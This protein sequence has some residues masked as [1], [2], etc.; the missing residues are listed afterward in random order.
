MF[1]YYMFFFYQLSFSCNN[2]DF[3]KLILNVAERA[4]TMRH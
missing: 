3:I 1:L 4:E 2:T